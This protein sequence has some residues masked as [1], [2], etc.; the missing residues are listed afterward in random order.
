ML[1]VQNK[2]FGCLR[3]PQLFKEEEMDYL[4]NNYKIKEQVNPQNP[5]FELLVGSN[6]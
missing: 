6:L 3:A 2:V 1:A 5:S 4:I